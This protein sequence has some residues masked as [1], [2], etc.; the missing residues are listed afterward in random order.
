[1]MNTLLHEMGSNP[2]TGGFELT[3]GVTDVEEGFFD[4]I[5][6]LMQIM[7]AP[8]VKHISVTTKP[9]RSLMGIML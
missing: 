2:R 7:I 8:S 3:E 1:M 5:P 9:R 4:N 6:N